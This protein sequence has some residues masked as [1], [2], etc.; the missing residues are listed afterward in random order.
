MSTE[1]EELARIIDP[2]ALELDAR[3]FPLNVADEILAAGWRRIPSDRITEKSVRHVKWLTTE[4]NNLRQSRNELRR[5]NIKLRQAFSRIREILKRDAA[6]DE[7]AGEYIDPILRRLQIANR[8]INRI[9]SV[10][11]E[12]EPCAKHHSNAIEV[13]DGMVTTA[14]RALYEGRV[15]LIESPAERA[16]W[17][18]WEGLDKEDA[19][20]WCDAARA[21]LEAALKEVKE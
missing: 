19:D 8:T 7:R 16:S 3:P 11:E 2:N 17:P 21:A 20:E 4:N 18:S 9:E 13:T 14:A 12:S 1:R 6:D 15:A 5:Q 10:I